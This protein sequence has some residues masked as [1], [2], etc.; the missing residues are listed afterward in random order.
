MY[1]IFFDKN[2]G[3]IEL[4][5]IIGLDDPELAFVSSDWRTIN[6]NPLCYYYMGLVNKSGEIKNANLAEVYL[7]GEN[8]DGIS[9]WYPHMMIGLIV[10]PVLKS[11]TPGG[12]PIE[13]SG[14]AESYSIPYSKDIV[15]SVPE[16]ELY[17]YEWAVDK[18]G[19]GFMPI[20]GAESASISLGTVDLSM[21]GYKYCCRV[22][23]HNPTGKVQTY[24]TDIVTLN[25]IDS[26]PL[27]R[28]TVS[29]LW[30]ALLIILGAVIIS[31]ATVRIAMKRKHTVIK[32]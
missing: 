12:A 30:V 21:N 10:V 27:T 20:D 13:V 4:P 26:A 24:M 7:S 1:E 22:I 29:V 25:L 32:K 16:N 2:E 9:N 28:D 15:L 5:G 6:L 8:R 31:L 19:N 23:Y 3:G 17:S 18:D 11:G 14:M